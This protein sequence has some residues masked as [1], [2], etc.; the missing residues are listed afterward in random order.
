MYPMIGRGCF[1]FALRPSCCLKISKRLQENGRIISKNAFSNRPW[2]VQNRRRDWGS[3]NP[4]FHGDNLIYSIIGIN[5]AVFAGWKVSENNRPLRRILLENFTVSS[6]GVLREFRI[7]TIITAIFSHSDIWHVGTNMLAVYF[8]GRQSLSMLGGPR[9]AML[10]LGGGLVSSLSQVLWPVIAPRQ[11]PSKYKTSRFSSALGSLMP[12][13]TFI[14]ATL[15]LDNFFSVRDLFIFLAGASGAVASVI[16]WSVL[17]SP[18][19]SVLLFFVVPVPAAILGQF[20]TLSILEC[21]D[22]TSNSCVNYVPATK[23]S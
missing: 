5:I 2:Q 9:F 10:Y 12:Y 22:I 1:L 11:T 18:N 14:S 6:N 13:K 16:T 7:H 4:I 21:G 3:N 15:V 19:A 20:A 17:T 23:S 8:F